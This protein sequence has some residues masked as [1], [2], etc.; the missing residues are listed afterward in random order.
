MNAIPVTTATASLLVAAN[1][2]RTSLIITVPSGTSLW[3]GDAATVSTT[4]GIE[5]RSPGSFTE[6]SGARRM[7]LGPYYGITSVGSFSAIV[8]ERT[9]L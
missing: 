5:I 9:S 8:W 3:M 4:T 6:D 2:N 1:P 7:Y